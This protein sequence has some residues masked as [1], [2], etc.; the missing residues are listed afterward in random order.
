MDV[1]LERRKPWFAGRGSPARV[2]ENLRQGFKY[3]EDYYRELEA[4]VA[5][6][7]RRRIIRC[8]LPHSR[9]IRSNGFCSIGHRFLIHTF[10]L[11]IFFFPEPHDGRLA[12]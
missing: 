12:R 5:A 6:F 4:I 1:T 7:Y 8:L 10:L 9:S 11:S 3:R 2:E